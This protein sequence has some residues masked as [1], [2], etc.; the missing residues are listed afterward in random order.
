MKRSYIVLTVISLMIAGATVAFSVISACTINKG[1]PADKQILMGDK[2]VLA[3][4]P[5]GT[6]FTRGV[7]GDTP[8]EDTCFS[9]WKNIYKID[10]YGYGDY[11]AGLTK[12][13]R[14]IVAQKQYEDDN[15]IGWETTGLCSD[16]RNIV[17]IAVDKYLIVGLKNDGTI[18]IEMTNNWKAGDEDDEWFKKYL[19]WSDIQ[20]VSVAR[21]YILG[22]DSLGEMVINE[23]TYQEL[24]LEEN[25]SNV[26]IIKNGIFTN[27]L[28]P[29]IFG[30]TEDGG[31]LYSTPWKKL[32]FVTKTF[33]KK[34]VNVLCDVNAFLLLLD[35]GKIAVYDPY[36]QTTIDS[37]NMNE[38]I[39]I[40]KV[41]S[42][43]S[44]GNEISS[45]GII[46]FVKPNGEVYSFY[47]SDDHYDLRKSDSLYKYFSLDG[48]KMR[49][50]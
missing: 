49:V 5:N 2:F 13:G 11:I 38:L 10:G 47:D 9:K 7:V 15:A 17:D 46:Y 31:L 33:D 36:S 18:C 21:G 26:A 42:I 27:H 23:K 22:I 35:D 32:Q 44:F 30:I 50:K 6:L 37:V 43:Y 29:I 24:I 19:T 48:Y 16:W 3:V 4:N 12:T 8:I 28:I 20:Y 40:E 39:G 14:V 34:A 25:I 41:Y 1:V 45:D